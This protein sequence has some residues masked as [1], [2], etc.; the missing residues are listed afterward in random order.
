MGLLPFSAVCK[1]NFYIISMVT[2]MIV[3]DKAFDS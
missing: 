3:F 2:V 1:L